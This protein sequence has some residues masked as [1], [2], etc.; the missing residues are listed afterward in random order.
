[1][2]KVFYFY[3]FNDILLTC[4]IN[5]VKLNLSRGGIFNVSAISVTPEQLRASAK[6]YMN[7][8]QDIQQQ[9]QRVQSENNNMAS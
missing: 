2:K 3:V 8:S 7:A 5:I 1:M 6:V 4:D 9:M